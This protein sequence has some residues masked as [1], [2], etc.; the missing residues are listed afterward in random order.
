MGGFFQS[1]SVAARYGKARPF[2]HPYVMKLVGEKLALAA[3]LPQ[4]LDVGCGTGQSSIALRSL[5]QQVLGLDNSPAMLQHALKEPGVSYQ[6]GQAEKLPVSDETID[7]VTVG[8]A[9]HWF[10]RQTFY[11]EAARVLRPQGHLVIYTHMLEHP[12]L[13]FF[14]QRYPSPYK[15]QPQIENEVSFFGFST[16]ANF[17]YAETLRLELKTTVD[18]LLTLSNVEAQLQSRALADI[19]HELTQELAP[20]FRDGEQDFRSH[21][22]IWILQKTD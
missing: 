4:A 2:F 20:H 5:A 15:F 3:P 19:E 1:E 12:C 13:S 8:Q 10:H 9:F 17:P 18:Y 7:L 21:G 11:L 22:I 6:F 16:R 14:P